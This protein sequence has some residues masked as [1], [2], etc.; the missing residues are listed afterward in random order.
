ML[1]K[2][3]I[4]IAPVEIANYNNQLHKGFELL[5]VD[6]DYVTY[7]DHHFKYSEKNN[8]PFL[9]LLSKK[10]GNKRN[11]IRKINP[12]FYPMLIVEL[13]LIA[14]W[15]FLAILKYDVFVFSF[16]RSL[17]PFNLDLPI[18]KW[19]GKVV[20]SNIG[21]GSESRPAYINGA[22]YSKDGTAPDETEILRRVRYSKRMIEWHQKYATHI[23]GAPLSTSYFSKKPFINW[24]DIGFPSYYTT[25]EYN[26]NRNNISKN[27]PIRILH[28]PSHRYV[29]GTEK[30][31]NIIS[32]LKREGYLIDYVEIEG[33]P[34]SQILLEIMKCDFIVDQLYSDTPMA[35]L[36][37]E[38]AWFSKPSVVAGYGLGK[39]KEVTHSDMWPPT[40]TCH[41]EKMKCAI[42]KMIDDDSLR[43]KI[44]D[45]SEGFVKDKWDARCVAKRYLKL[46][47]N[48]IPA[49]WYYHPDT[50][51]YVE[52]VGLSREEIKCSVNKIIKNKGVD[53]LGLSHRPEVENAFLEFIKEP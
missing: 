22:L 29:K 38:A 50:V 44:G 41:P 11:K 10:I 28:C 26:A 24:F 49:D 19:M 27:K 23:I 35:G 6:C 47:K 40:M 2:K 53:S 51:I 30:I 46:I 8:D 16:G 37:K 34:F 18:L 32:E 5:G 45:L 17:F 48:D 9:I 31:F 7:K 42:K 20:I 13:I 36:S 52:G 14:I 39:L 21:L 1:T 15:A 3:K 25:S 43:K 4:L 33:V 12:F